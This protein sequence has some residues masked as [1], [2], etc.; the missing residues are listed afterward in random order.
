[1]DQ[2][3]DPRSS[4]VRGRAGWPRGMEPTRVRLVVDR[5]GTWHQDQLNARHMV[6]LNV[7]DPVA[8]NE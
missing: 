7:T 5:L 2:L 4:T 8:A 1:M 6:D 3:D